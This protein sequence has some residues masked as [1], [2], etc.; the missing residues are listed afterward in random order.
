MCNSVN[1]EI[2]YNLVIMSDLPYLASTLVNHPPTSTRMNV[3]N[4][5]KEGSQAEKSPF[6]N[7]HS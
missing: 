2:W 5:M 7:V 3:I 6:M 4:I 1:G